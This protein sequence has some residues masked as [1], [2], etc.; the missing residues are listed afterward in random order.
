VSPPIPLGGLRAEVARLRAD[1]NSIAAD[2]A[3]LFARQCGEAPPVPKAADYYPELAP[4]WLAPVIP[5]HRTGST[6]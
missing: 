5:L 4:G 3:L 1:L 2:F 6:P